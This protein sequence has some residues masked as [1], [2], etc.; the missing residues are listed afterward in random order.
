[1][2]SGRCSGVQA[3]AKQVAKYTFYVHC[4]THGLNLVVV[5]CLKKVL[6]SGDFFINSSNC[7]NSC[8]AHL[9]TKS[10]LKY[11]PKC[12]VIHHENYKGSVTLGGSAATLHVK[13]F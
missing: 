2:M 7:K 3:R 5:D 6:E 1:M 12:S 13:T 8:Q 9:S 4:N 11:K 10:G